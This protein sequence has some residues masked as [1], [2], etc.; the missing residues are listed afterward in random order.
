MK[1]HDEIVKEITA[2]VSQNFRCF[3]GARP[4]DGNPIAATMEGRPP[5][6][7]AGVDIA[8]VVSFVLTEAA[9]GNN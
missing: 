5:S 3:G 6:F 1:T 4:T 9:R 7:A 8:Q 2:K